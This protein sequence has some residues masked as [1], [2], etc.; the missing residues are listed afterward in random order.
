[1]KSIVYRRTASILA[2]AVLI[3]GGVIFTPA[4]ARAQG[5]ESLQRQIEALQKAL[6]AVKGQLEKIRAEQAAQKARLAKQ[7]KER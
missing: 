4:P 2:G 7:E 3:A 6:D 5:V 1:M